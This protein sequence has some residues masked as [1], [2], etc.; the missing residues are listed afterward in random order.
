MI[1]ILLTEDDINNKLAGA[2]FRPPEGEVSKAQ[3]YVVEVQEDQQM[4]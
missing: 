3:K 4:D 1:L 2:S